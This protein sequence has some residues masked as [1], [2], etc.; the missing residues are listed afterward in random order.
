M[1]STG[2][3]IQDTIDAAAT[4]M[5]NAGQVRA[6]VPDCQDDADGERRRDDGREV[7]RGQR[8]AERQQ[9]GDERSWLLL[10]RE[11]QQFLKLAGKD[12]SGD[13]RRKPY[14]D[15]VGDELDIGSEPQKS[16]CQQ[17]EA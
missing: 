10:Q 6:I 17:Y 2:R 13:P 5:M 3:P 8:A 4:A 7:D 16:Y 15:R 9:L 12:D 14:Y 1:V 11:T